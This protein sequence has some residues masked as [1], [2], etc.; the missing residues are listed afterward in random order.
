MV[1]KLFVKT[2]LPLMEQFYSIQ[3]EGFY[4]GHAAYFIRLAGCDVGCVWC[5]VKESWDANLHQEVGIEKM[6][7]NAKNSG[8]EIVVVTG[9]EPAM[10][11]LDALTAEIKKQ[12]LRSHIE[13]SGAYEVTGSWDWFCLSP[14][15]F[16]AP[17]DSV[18]KQ[19]DELKIIVFNKSDFEWAEQQAAKVN[20]S[21]EL[22]LQ[23]EWSKEKEMMPHIINYVKEN[24]QWKISLQIHKYMSIP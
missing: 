14:K 23:P 20:S 1:S 3:G 5:D 15:K 10:Y 24:P 18:F 12:N 22:Y 2:K 7:H 6:V 9:G 13:T 4:Q 19:A 8:T 21:C 16:K 11:N 17:V